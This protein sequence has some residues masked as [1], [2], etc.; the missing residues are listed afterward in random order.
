[1]IR[2]IVLVKFKNNISNAEIQAVFK[3]LDDLRKSIPEIISY[4]WGEYRSK[5]GL[6]KGFTHS[7]V[8]KFKDENARDIYLNHPEHKR[9]AEKIV[10]PVLEDGFNSVIAFD[11][12][13][14]NKKKTTSDTVKNSWNKVAT[15]SAIIGIASV[16]LYALSRIFSNNETVSNSCI[17]SSKLSM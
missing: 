5:E 4:S 7:F 2:H 17:P 9:V 15:C 1:M 14:S 3:A 8:M 12:D 11:Y 10:L 16:G 13:K 6:N